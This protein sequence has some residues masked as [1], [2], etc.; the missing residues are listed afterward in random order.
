MSMQLEREQVVEYC[1]KLDAS[2]LS[3]GTSGNISIFNA[4]EQLMA[5]T[6]SSMDYQ[7]LSADDIVLMDLSANVVAGT[8]R[9][10]TEFD[11]H[12]NCYRERSDIAAVVH[13]HSPQATTLA[14]LGW[15]WPK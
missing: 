6:P 7:Q 8:R 10:S 12:L 14:V 11:M 9:P 13:T 2:G 5:I 3:P 4:D 1:R 15:A